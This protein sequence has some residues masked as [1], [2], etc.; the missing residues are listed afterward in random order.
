[1]GKSDVNILIVDDN[2]MVRKLVGQYLEAAFPQHTML[3]AA[4]GEEAVARARTD[5]PSIII[6]DIGLPK[7]NGIETTKTIKAELPSTRVVMLTIHEENSYR[8]EARLAGADG[9]V[10]K[11][12]MYA[13]LMPVLSDW[14]VK[15]Q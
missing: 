15:G 12:T 6:M 9:Y 14:L 2:A 4:S 7:M 13:E 5:R 1:M 8:D 11:R 10:P 3:E